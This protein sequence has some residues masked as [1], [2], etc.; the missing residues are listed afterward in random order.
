MC[1]KMAKN[2]KPVPETKSPILIDVK[3][4]AKTHPN[5]FFEVSPIVLAEVRPYD[6]VKL[7]V[8]GE[9]FWVEVLARTSTHWLGRIQSKP[10]FTAQHGLRQDDVVKF[11]YE[12]VYEV[13]L[14]QDEGSNDNAKN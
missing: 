12:N 8:V 3:R 14:R 7:G 4:M 2:V 9:R 10:S 13:A 5:R 1:D 11:T 6:Y